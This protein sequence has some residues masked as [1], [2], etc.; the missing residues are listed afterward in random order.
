[1]KLKAIELAKIVS[2]DLEGNSEEIISGVNG[3]ADAKK[4][5]ISF[6][7]NMKYVHEALNTQA[8]VIFVAQDTDSSQFENKTLIYYM[9]N[10]FFDNH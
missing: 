6:L 1:M 7:G 3:L 8:S 5:E 4:G 10:R 2:G 9:F